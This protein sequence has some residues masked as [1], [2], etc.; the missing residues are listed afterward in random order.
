[1][2]RLTDIKKDYVTGDT[3][4]NALKGVSLEFRQSEFVSILGQSGCGKTT[5]LNIIGGL[6]QYTSGDLVINGK[7]TKEFDD[8]DW[9]TY[10]NHSVGFIFQSYNL[11]PHQTVLANVELALTLSGVSKEERRKRAIEALETVGLGEQIK[12]KPNQLSGG[13]MQRVAIARALV[14]NPDILLA[15]EPTGA[16]D[17]E[18]SVQIME[19]LKAISNDK[20]IIMVTHNPDLAEQ[21]STRIINLLDGNVVNDSNPYCSQLDKENCEKTATPVDEIDISSLTKEEIKARKKAQRE[22]RKRERLERKKTSMSFKTALSLSLNNLM[23][24]KGRTFLTSFAGSIG[25]IGI[26]LILSVS[27]GVNA[28]ITSIEEGT[29]S[30]YPLQINESTTDTLGIMGTIAQGNVIENPD[31]NTVYSNDVMVKLMESVTSSYT[32]N[33]LTA[34]KQ[35]LDSNETIQNNKTDIKYVYS[36]KLNAYRIVDGLEKYKATLNGI[37]GLLN[38]IG[39][40]EMFGMSESSSNNMSFGGDAFKELVGDSEYIES[41]YNVLDGRLPSKSNEVVLIVDSS[42]QVSDFILYTL[43][44]RDTLE[45]EQYIQ[46]TIAGK[47]Y[48]IESQTY[49]FEQIRGYKFKVLPESEKY[50]VVDGKIVMR[51]QEE[52]NKYLDENEGLTLEIVGIV[53]PSESSSGINLGSIGYTA[54]LMNNVIAE[55]NSNELITIQKENTETDLLTGL[56]FEGFDPSCDY[57][58]AF[59][60]SNTELLGSM[61]MVLTLDD[62]ALINYLKDIVITDSSVK[63]LLTFEGNG[64]GMAPWGGYTVADTQR[65]LEA[66]NSIEEE[67][68]KSFAGMLYSLSLSGF[69]QTDPTTGK[70]NVIGA[71]P[72]GQN[73]IN[74]VNTMLYE[75]SSYTPEQAH[76]NALTKLGYVD[77]NKPT[78]ILIYPKDFD[79][80]GIIKEEINEYNK[81]QSEENVITYS[82]TFEDLMKAVT[83]IVNAISYVLVAFVAISLVVS[84]IMIGIIT[85]ISVLE[86]TKEIGILRAIGASK[87]DV[88]RVF[89]AETLIVGFA[90]GVIGIVV[91][92]F[93][94]VIINIILNALTGLETLRATLPWAAAI[95]LVLISMGL[96]LIAGIF[97]SRIAAKKDPVIALRTE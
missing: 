48:K 30:S 51:T 49:T 74:V 15:D 73:F 59:I 53:T 72:T 76:L 20:L 5:L 42:Q 2:L 97:P 89:N 18:T 93:F 67:Q 75:N 65:I 64:Q 26:A 44:I 10:R 17:S 25:I 6:D 40:G 27:A 78:S 63:K 57:I 24:K 9:D 91:S 85:Y 38:E 41:Q 94:I 80:K 83:T 56:P 33:N 62:V 45:L 13:Q 35:F 79:A 68:I 28:Y 46:A 14:N 55:S 34:F 77:F 66:F 23:T 58:K 16:L 88:S 31:P 43:G 96:T 7:S 87:K 19:L 50:K 1:M 90:A 37:V 92:L 29:M 70:V 69:P 81:N 54:E 71:D 22:A 8:R 84:S 82:D 86:R 39:L 12:K 4:V 61:G 95:V 60:A 36:T 21:Y 47:E 32:K 3:T 11:I 52:I